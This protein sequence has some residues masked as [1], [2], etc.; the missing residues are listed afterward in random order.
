M[1]DPQAPIQRRGLTAIDGSMALIVLLL[2]VQMYLLSATLEAYLSGHHDAAL[3]GAILSGLI[4]AASAAL[5]VF[6][7]RLDREARKG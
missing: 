3:P 2:L 7:E 1:R 6:V 4:F 5:Y